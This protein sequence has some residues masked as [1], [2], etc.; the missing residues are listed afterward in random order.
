MGWAVAENLGYRQLTTLWRL[1]GLLSY[2]RGSREWG[3][4]TRQGFGAGS[5]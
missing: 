5:G 3:T 4:M 2:A 1:R